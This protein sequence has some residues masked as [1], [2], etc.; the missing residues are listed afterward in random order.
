MLQGA[1]D[2]DVSQDASGSSEQRF[3]R[4]F[5]NVNAR[6][7]GQKWNSIGAPQSGQGRSNPAPH[8]PAIPNHDFSAAH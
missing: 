2:G 5:T 3:R 1:S 4:S 7:T 8:N 6:A